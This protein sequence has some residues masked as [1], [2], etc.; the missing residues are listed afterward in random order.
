M[1]RLAL[2]LVAGSGVPA[3]TSVP[4]F[5]AAPGQQHTTGAAPAES[6]RAALSVRDPSGRSPAPAARGPSARTPGWQSCRSCQCRAPSR[7]LRRSIS[8]ASNAARSGRRPV[9]LGVSPIRM[10]TVQTGEHLAVLQRLRPE[11]ITTAI[12][13]VARSRRGTTVS[14]NRCRR[15]GSPSVLCQRS[16]PVPGT[17]SNSSSCCLSSLAACSSSSY[18][19]RCCCGQALLL[20][21]RRQPAGEHGRHRWRLGAFP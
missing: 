6:S 20:R 19:F 17:I 4:T 14:T 8:C 10:E 1:R 21:P 12:S 16:R 5:R 3:R 9:A 13:A 7:P 18:K 15:R 11:T 2:P